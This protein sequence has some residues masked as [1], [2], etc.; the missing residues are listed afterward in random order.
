MTHRIGVA[1]ISNQAHSCGRQFDD[2]LDRVAVD[3]T[4]NDDTATTLRRHATNPT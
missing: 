2:R 4:G 3:R 1:T